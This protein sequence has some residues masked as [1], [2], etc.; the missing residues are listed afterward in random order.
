MIEP[1]P[2]QTRVLEVPEAWSMLL[3]GGRGGGKSTTAS[4]LVL[5][6]VEKYRADARPLLIRETHK[7]V[8]ELEDQ[9]DALFHNSYGRGV[10]LNRADHVFRLP[11]GAQVELGQ[12]ATPGDYKKYQGRSK[13]LLVVDEYGL[14][15]DRRWVELLKSN[16]R[17]PADIPLR[18]ILAA[19]PGG[20]LHAHV[21]QT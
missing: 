4:L 15:R 21:H 12:L 20:S 3:A 13:T 7:A 11:N 8:T 9:L 6:H 16:L 5:R 14:L 1:T 19:N 18:T 17:S 2:Y 10:K